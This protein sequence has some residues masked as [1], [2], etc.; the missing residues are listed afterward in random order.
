LINSL[1][2]INTP[3]GRSKTAPEVKPC[4]ASDNW[5]AI[6][7]SP[8]LA[9][10]DMLVRARV[11]G[12]K[13]GLLLG[14]ANFWRQQ[15][16]HMPNTD[17]QP[18]KTK[19]KNQTT[20]P[21][22]PQKTLEDDVVALMRKRVYDLAGVLGKTVKVY[23]NGERLPVKSYADY[24]DLYLGPKEAGVPRVYE[25]VNDRCAR[26]GVGVGGCCLF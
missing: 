6:T 3:N 9:K 17:P 20:R 2:T 16:A 1:K 4:K 19:T 24:V 12:V 14:M 5:T 13:G 11:W 25:R 18:L 15:L 7:F 21:P 26:E 22:P 23:L 8:D 10:F